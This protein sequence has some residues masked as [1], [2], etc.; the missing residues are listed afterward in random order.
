LDEKHLRPNQMRIDKLE[1][2]N[3]KKFAEKT[4][5][6]DPQFTLLVGENGAGKTTI[7]DALAVALGVWLIKPPDS[8][9]ANDRRP[10]HASEKRLT[11]I[12]TGDRTLF[13]EAPGEVSI[14]AIGQIE[15]HDNIS[16][17]Q[18]IG[19]GRS[20]ASSIGSKKAINIIQ[21][22]FER[23][24]NNEQRVLP[25]IGYFGA[26]RASLPHNKRTKS[27]PAGKA[28]RWAAFYDC[29]N[30]RIRTTDL[31]QWFW[32]ETTEAGN[33]SGAFRPG[34][35]VVRRA[36]INCVPGAEGVWF[37]VDRKDIVLSIEQNPQPFGNLSAG[38]RM[39]L[40]L[41][42]DIA[43]K[44]VTQNNFL[45]PSHSL[46]SDDLPL[47]RVLKETPGVILIDELDV[48]LHPNWQRRVVN[49]LK[50]TFPNIQF[51]CT[52]HSPQIIGEVPS[53]GIRLLDC[54]YPNDRPASSFGVDTNAILEEVMG[55]QSRNAVSDEAIGEVES[56][57][58]EGNLGLARVELAELM[59]LQGTHT[60]DTARLEATIN[61]LEALADEDD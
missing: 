37:D 56:A 3:F 45:V 39:M 14:N 19:K 7:L 24:D 10:I 53:D 38:Q 36:I 60:R 20:K 28:K 48:H 47:P 23:A 12:Q 57:L 50:S 11:S 25:I 58:N 15:G 54:E 13:Q 41:V 46:S 33:R 5:D 31:V 52:T 32:D 44:A 34:F 17:K 21:N 51:I 35:E 29:L 1:I 42:A 27:P 2:R 26:G 9:L 61:N 30:Q 55:A 49:D 4:I 8:L 16:W 43:I 6:L 18:A 59:E 40:S 22:A